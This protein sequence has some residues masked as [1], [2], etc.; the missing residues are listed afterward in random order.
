MN[1]SS[2][3]LSL[4]LYHLA[5]E[6]LAPDSHLRHFYPLL[7]REGDSERAEFSW[8]HR[9]IARESPAGPREI[10]ALP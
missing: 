7:I 3:C 5:P 4:S 10:P 9:L 2:L 8:T 6:P 1:Q